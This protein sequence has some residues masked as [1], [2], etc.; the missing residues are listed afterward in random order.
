MITNNPNVTIQNP[1]ITYRQA[2]K[3]EVNYWKVPDK[4]TGHLYIFGRIGSGKSCK[5][6]T[7]AQAFIE[8]GYKIWDMDGGKRNEGAFWCFPNDDYALWEQ[9]KSETY[10]FS[11]EGPKQY[12]V[13]LLYPMFSSKM[14]RELPS[15]PPNIKSKI[16]TIPFREL[17]YKDLSLVLG[18]IG[19]SYKGLWE[20]IL[21]NTNSKDNGE[22][23]NFLL[24]TQLEQFKNRS[25]YTLFLRPLIDNHLFSSE[26]CDLNLDL[27][28]EANEID[29]I[30]VLCLDYIPKDFHFFIRGYIMKKLLNLVIDNVIHKKNITIFREASS[31]MKVV[32][33]DKSKE[34]TA[35]LFRSI[36]VDDIGRY[37]RSGVFLAMDTQDSSEVKGLL[38]GQS[39]LMGICEMPSQRSREVTCTPLKSDRRMNDAQIRY[40][41]TM[42]IHQIC[43]VERGKKSKILK[44]IQPPRCKYWKETYGNFVSQWKKEVD[45]WTKTSNFTDIIEEEYHDHREYNIIRHQK[46]L[47]SKKKKK[48]GEKKIK[49]LEIDGEEDFVNVKDSN[50]DSDSVSELVSDSDTKT[51]SKSKNKNINKE[52]DVEKEI[53]KDDYSAVLEP[54]SVFN[55]N[56]KNKDDND[57]IDFNSNSDN[58][59]EE[60]DLNTLELDN[61]NDDGQ[62][63]DTQSERKQSPK[64]KPKRESR[65]PSNFEE[66]G[67]EISEAVFD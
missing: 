16:F 34:D 51:L 8:K 14:P 50:N 45:L 55:E 43:I 42:P 60:E 10:D 1:M 12:K 54:T 26:K 44:R 41:S 61:I 22:D 65:K 35:S 13:N 67:F 24:K 27:I 15:N 56:N 28:A 2:T 36:I 52:I 37:G 57:N 30:S 6:L 40:I 19:V 18:A 62:D 53:E 39:D 25:V 48:V 49:V 31:F 9:V 63:R 7:F 5:L 38:D 29:T 3:N 21:R 32:D 64:S 23:I 4:L 58:N 47:E 66:G 20:E 33:A 11:E 17:E 46:Y 59:N